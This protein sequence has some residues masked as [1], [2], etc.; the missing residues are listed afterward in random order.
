M[1]FKIGLNLYRLNDIYGFGCVCGRAVG[2]SVGC[3][4][5]QLAAQRFSFVHSF[6]F[7]QFW[8]GKYKTSCSFSFI[9]CD[10]KNKTKTTTIDIEITA[11]FLRRFLYTYSSLNTRC[12]LA[13]WDSCGFTRRVSLTFNP[14]AIA[15]GKF[16]IRFLFVL[17][18]NDH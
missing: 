3:S 7:I 1:Q 5:L 15:S 11:V 2:R 18:L 4:V 10:S 13:N 9:R 12:S 17:N 8:Y 16:F 6:Q 14:N